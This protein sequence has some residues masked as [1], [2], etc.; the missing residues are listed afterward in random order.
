MDVDNLLSIALALIMFSVGTSLEVADFK[1]VF[2]YPKAL[3]T[4]LSL[5]MVFLP[6]LAF[7][8]CA[9]VPISIDF[10]LGILI[11]TLCPGG[12]TSNFINYLLDL[13][14]ALS[15]S[16]TLINTVLILFTV[17]LGYSIFAAY[18]NKEGAALN[19]DFGTTFYSIFINVL[20]PVF[21]GI[22]FRQMFLQ[23]VTKITK[24]LKYLSSLL[25]AIVFAIKIFAGEDQGGAGL[26]MGE[27]LLI[28]PILLIIHFSSMFLSYLLS[29]A[30]KIE[31]FRALT[32]SI[33]VGLQNTTLALLVTSVYLANTEMSKPSIVY[34]MFSFFTTLMFGYFFKHRLQKSS[35]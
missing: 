10:K 26:E 6:I 20:L 27:I 8:I 17:P 9:F 30:I 15:I 25:L 35:L 11:L 34:A 22:V 3:I 16:L 31:Q 28:M 4:G 32:I 23:L 21:L 1:N 29:K 14:T 12:A 2:K 5:Q 7:L 24:P 19:L 33:E 13:K 18:F